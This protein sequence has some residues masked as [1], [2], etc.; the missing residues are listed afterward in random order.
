MSD[1]YFSLGKPIKVKSFKR[2]CAPMGWLRQDIL[3]NKLQTNREF[4]NKFSKE[5][6]NEII[7]KSLRKE[8]R[9]K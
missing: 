6:L 9:V 2:H 1:K 4:R 8:G 3:L 7:L 5:E